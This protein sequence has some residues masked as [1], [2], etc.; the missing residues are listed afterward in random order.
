MTNQTK[1]ISLKKALSFAWSTYYKHFFYFFKISFSY[2]LWIALAFV[3]L[4]ILLAIFRTSLTITLD[5]SAGLLGIIIF[6]MDEFFTVA[7]LKS[8]FSFYNNPTKLPSPEWDIFSKN[9]YRFLLARILYILALSLGFMALILPGIYIYFKY[10]F[11]GFS[12]LEKSNTLTDDRRHNAHITSRAPWRLLGYEI[13]I[14]IVKGIL[15]A[16]LITA[17]FLPLV[18]LTKMHLYKQ[19]SEKTLAS[20]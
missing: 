10:Y 18:E 8:G 16:G 15:N 3:A 7:L 12:V 9:T 17:I 20:K 5:L 2:L 1:N 4:I 11:T 13:I 19:L 6:L 14:S